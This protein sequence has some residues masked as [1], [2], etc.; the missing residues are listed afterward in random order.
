VISRGVF[1][2]RSLL[3]LV[4]KQENVEKKVYEVMEQRSKPL[5]SSQTIAGPE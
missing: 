4:P 1:A 3:S 2:S 5:V